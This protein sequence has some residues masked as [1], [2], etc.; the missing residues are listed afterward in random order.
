LSQGQRFE[1]YETPR[2]KNP[3][4]ILGWNQDVAG[5]GSMTLE[6]LIK[7]L[8][9]REFAQIKPAGFFPLTGVPVEQNIIQFPQSKF[10]F[11]EEH[12]LLIFHSD[13]PGQSHYEFLTTL[14]DIAGQTSAVKEMYTVGGIVSLMAHNSPRRV[15][16][17]V[18]QHELKQSLTKYDVNTNLEYETPV[19]ARP[20]LSSLFL[21][22][23]QK[24][25]IA[26]ANLWVDVP[27]YLAALEDPRACKQVL[28]VLD[29]RFNL[30]LDFTD[31]DRDIEQQNRLITQLMEKES[32]VHKYISM[33]ERGIMLSEKESEALATKVAEILQ[34]TD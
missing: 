12:D 25:N 11:C 6:F 1:I 28:S 18:N 24:R 33:L 32:D 29:L 23:A 30:G 34:K 9:A 27:F 26:G 14:L 2:L 20:T 8:N 22:V 13:G 15:S 7:K 21:W 16:S 3:C 4:L 17:V 31:L 5:L 19:G 10:Y